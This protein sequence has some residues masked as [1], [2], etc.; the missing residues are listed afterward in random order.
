VTQFLPNWNLEKRSSKGAAMALDTAAVGVA[1][2][3]DAADRPN[4][5]QS[6]HP[7][8]P[9]GHQ[10]ERVP[11]PINEG[12]SVRAFTPYTPSEMSMSDSASIPE[13]L[14]A[15][16]TTA[17]A[18]TATAAGAV[19]VTGV[20]AAAAAAGT[21]TLARKASM[22]NRNPNN[23]DLTVAGLGG[24]P[25]SPA[26]T[27]FSVSSAT[28]G[29]MPTPSESAA[30]IAAAG[31]PANSTVHRVQLDFNSTLDDELDLKAGDVV[32]LLHEYDDGWVST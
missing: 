12:G 20:V 29:P 7:A 17:V 10:A 31:G 15:E 23:V 16:E 8:N 28:P 27:D 13:V 19:A 3:G 5:S 2:T 25:P 14:N 26:G 9:F 1:V 30:A 24:V 21:S 6:D 22:R 18:V 11:S 32:R 4:T